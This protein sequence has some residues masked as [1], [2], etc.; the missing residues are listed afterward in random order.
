MS[1]VGEFFII[2]CAAA[3]V[4]LL[5]NISSSQKDVARSLRLEVCFHAIE[6]GVDIKQAVRAKVCP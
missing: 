2:I 3:S 6:I 1:P 4:M 5:A